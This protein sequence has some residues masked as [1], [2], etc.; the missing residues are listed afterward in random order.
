MV[1]ARDRLSKGFGD[2]AFTNIPDRATDRL[3][4]ETSEPSF[5]KTHPSRILAAMSSPLIDAKLLGTIVH[6]L[7]N[8][9]NVVQLSTRMID[10]MRGMEGAN[11]EEDLAILRQNTQQLELMLQLLG[12]YCRQYETESLLNSMRFGTERL[13][14]DAI[15]LQREMQAAGDCNRVIESEIRPSAPAYL[16]LDLS[17]ARLA[18]GMALRNA[19]STSSNGPTRIIAEGDRDRVTF[20][21]KVE[22]PA[23]GAPQSVDLRADAFE[24]LLPVAAER[25][26]LDLAIAAR[27]SELF[28]GTARL[29]FEGAKSSSIILQWPVALNLDATTSRP[30]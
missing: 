24:R 4:A 26:A 15:E 20:R 10:Q 16:D 19:M 13:V 17:R 8:P 6:D 12:D 27:V 30:A 5:S 11:L 25:R 7:R 14:L 9:L 28:G 23:K 29:E 18:L 2:V 3:F 22:E 21:V 1:F